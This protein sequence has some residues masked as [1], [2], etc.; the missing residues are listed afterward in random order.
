V[1]DLPR[2]RIIAY[3][4]DPRILKVEIEW[5]VWSLEPEVVT[6]CPYEV[7]HYYRPTHRLELELRYARSLTELNAIVREV[8]AEL[9][10]E[11]ESS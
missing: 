5:A 3:R 11:M 6:I 8:E 2:R 4:L 10:R 9:N 7:L 1:S